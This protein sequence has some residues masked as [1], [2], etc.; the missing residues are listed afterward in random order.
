MP[1]SGFTCFG[2]IQI[3]QITDKKNGGKR[4][5]KT[6]Q[7]KPI[8]CWSR[9]GGSIE[10]IT[11]VVFHLRDR[12]LWSSPTWLNIWERHNFAR[13]LQRCEPFG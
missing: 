8:A 3:V 5:K 12:F 7:T 10:S 6:A 9:V 1:I 11:G 2:E 4:H 13:F